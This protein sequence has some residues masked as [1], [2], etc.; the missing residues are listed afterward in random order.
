MYSSM[1][2]GLYKSPQLMFLKDPENSLLSVSYVEMEE[3][4]NEW[5]KA[6]S[7]QF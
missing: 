2:V 3:K 6:R 4:G 1:C 7:S 5:I